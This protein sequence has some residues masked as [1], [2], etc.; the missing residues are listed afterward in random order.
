MYNITI[1]SRI[2][3]SV[4]S[5]NTD[6]ERRICNPLAY[7]NNFQPEGLKRREKGHRPAVVP[8]EKWHFDVSSKKWYG[9]VKLFFISRFAAPKPRCG[10]RRFG[11][12]LS[13]TFSIIRGLPFGKYILAVIVRRVS[14]PVVVEDLGEYSRVPVE[15]VFVEYWVIVGQ[16]FG[17]TR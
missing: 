13:K 11:R 14:V 5:K 12:V 17:Q 3:A 7:N 15:E 9:C 4:A 1:S 2:S 16:C 6:C 10:F 8:N